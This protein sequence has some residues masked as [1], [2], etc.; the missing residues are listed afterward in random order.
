M[1]TVIGW[2][3]KS[4]IKEKTNTQDIQQPQRIS[5]EQTVGRTEEGH[6]SCP[7]DGLVDRTQIERDTADC[8]V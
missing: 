3:R 6:Q 4:Y 7:K 5:Q 1:V 2:V 8:Q